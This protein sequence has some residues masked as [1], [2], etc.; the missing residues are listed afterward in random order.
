LKSFR[1]KAYI[2]KLAEND[3]TLLS[4]SEAVSTIYWQKDI[5]FAE[6]VLA[7]TSAKQMSYLT[8][9][10]IG[11][12]DIVNLEVKYSFQGWLN[13]V[14]GKIQIYSRETGFNTE[15]GYETD[16]YGI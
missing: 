2:R 9:M 14:E 1:A 5:G 15:S 4:L 13:R 3:T 12:K 8:E 16:L 6:D 11:A 10:S 7:K